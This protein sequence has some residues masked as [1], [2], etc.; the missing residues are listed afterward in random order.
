MTPIEKMAHIDE[1]L[2]LYDEYEDL[3][4]IAV[5]ERVRWTGCTYGEAQDYYDRGKRAAEAS[6]CHDFVVGCR[7]DGV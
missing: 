1:L 7:E 3:A 4:N 2:D 6:A 5:Q